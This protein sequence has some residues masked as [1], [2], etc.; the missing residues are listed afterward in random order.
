M[1]DVAASEPLAQFLHAGQVKVRHGEHAVGERLLQHVAVRLRTFRALGFPCRPVDAAPDAAQR[2]RHEA[3]CR[4]AL[5][6]RGPRPRGEVA[7]AGG[8]HIRLGSHGEET[9]RRGADHVAHAAVVGLDGA[10]RRVE[11]EGCA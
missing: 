11:A 3:A 2:A 6:K 9:A 8:V 4:V 1:P 5:F 10:E 7:V